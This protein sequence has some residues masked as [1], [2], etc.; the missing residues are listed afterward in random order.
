[1]KLDLI[2]DIHLDHWKAWT[3]T[4][5]KLQELKPKSDILIIAGDLSNQ[6]EASLEFL[7]QCSDHYRHTLLVLGN[8][9]WYSFRSTEGSVARIK[10]LKDG[11]TKLP[12]VH[13]LEGNYLEIDGVTFYGFTGWY[14]GEYARKHLGLSKNMI[15]LHWHRNMND[16]RYI[17]TAKRFDTMFK[18]NP[19][20]KKAADVVI[21]HVN[22]SINQ[23]FQDKRYAHMPS[24]T[25][26]CFD[27]S[28]LRKILKPKLWV[29][30]HN[31]SPM[32]YKIYRTDYVSNPLGYPH[33]T[34]LREVVQLEVINE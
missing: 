20:P 19:K 31:H 8:H 1:M 14:D 34:D 18:K 30:G 9:D 29:F 32:T 6:N 26:Y 17:T 11:I 16:S 7:K 23:R 3:G 24:N 33:E 27:G 5:L 21:T 28:G 10:E 13:L 2:S 4:D 12:N 25:F 22:P 15:N